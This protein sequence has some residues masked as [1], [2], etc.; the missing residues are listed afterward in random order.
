MA[1]LCPI[2]GVGGLTYSSRPAI[3]S[4][5]AMKSKTIRTSLDIPAPL[6]RRL[7]EAALRRGCSARQLILESI[8]HVVEEDLPQPER[9]LRLPLVPAAGRKIQPV[10]NDETLFS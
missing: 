10:S 5:L 2:A 3:L 1:R 8:E 9:H 4:L 7:H 6:H